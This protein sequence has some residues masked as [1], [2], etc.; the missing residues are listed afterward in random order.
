MGTVM[1]TEVFSQFNPNALKVVTP[2]YPNVLKLVAL[3][4]GCNCS[5]RI[6]KIKQFHLHAE[7]DILNYIIYLSI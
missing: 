7:P 1:D 3:F 5:I 4:M 2:F 6:S